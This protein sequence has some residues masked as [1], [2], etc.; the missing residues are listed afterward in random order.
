MKASLLSN[1][2]GFLDDDLLEE[3]EDFRSAPRPVIKKKKAEI[4]FRLIAQYGSIAACVLLVVILALSKGLPELQFPTQSEAPSDGNSV[5]WPLSTKDPSYQSNSTA[6]T[7][8]AEPTPS[9]EPDTQEETTTEGSSESTTE[10]P[11]PTPIYSEGLLYEL[12]AQGDSYSV[13]G[14][15][16][17]ADEHIVVPPTYLGLPITHF[18]GFANCKTIKSVTLPN[19]I[20]SIGASPFMGCDHLEELTLPFIPSGGTIPFK[21]LFDDPNL[22]SYEMPNIK[23]VEL[24]RQVDLPANTFAYCDTIESV[25]LPNTLK[26]IG[27]TSFDGCRSLREITIPSSVTSIGFNALRSCYNLKSITVNANIQAL[28]A[29]FARDCINLESV[30]LSPSIKTIGTA[31]FMDCLK[32]ADDGFLEGVEQIEANAFSGC[33]FIEL[34]LPSSIQYVAGEAFHGCDSLKS[35][36]I[37]ATFC[38]I[39]PYAFSGS[40]ALERITAAEGIQNYIAKGNCLIEVNSRS[41]ILG[42]KT[43]EIPSD[44]G[45][46]AIGLGAFAYN[47]QLT[48][49]TIPDNVQSIGDSAF[50]HCYSL[51]SVAFAYGLLSLGSD[52]FENCTKLEAILLPITVNTLGT[53]VFNGCYS[54]K[55]CVLG[56]ASE[57]PD[58]TFLNCSSLQALEMGEITRIGERA[59]YNCTSL[60]TL[61][62]PRSLRELDMSVLISCAS[63]GVLY[64]NGT[65]TDWESIS[66]ANQNLISDFDVKVYIWSDETTSHW[67]ALWTGEKW[68]FEAND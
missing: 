53:A 56:S 34:T 58:S 20:T 49:I 43:S 15:G 30:S 16:S 62:L 64:Y 29:H 8:E 11:Q 36:H 63:L 67:R 33:A 37:E 14:I 55:T 28:P 32:L 19:S 68:E 25:I 42:C 26:S 13:K 21:E 48:S 5:E 50:S 9:T 38:Q 6:A 61:Y 46:L 44:V 66:F 23:R 47:T 27:K 57:I 22:N 24:T 2:I 39:Q 12:S 31:A 54:L 52:V 65:A 51:K 35:L 17:C 3:A 59:F 4:P 45:P 7:T 41:V 18:A 1:A 60:Q 10:E 40:S